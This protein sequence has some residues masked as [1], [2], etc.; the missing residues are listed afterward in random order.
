MP[1]INLSDVTLKDVPVQDLLLRL[2]IG[3]KAATLAGLGVCAGYLA[4]I[5]KRLQSEAPLSAEEFDE[6]FA[7]G[8]QDVSDAYNRIRTVD[9]IE[10]PSENGKADSQE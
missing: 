4:A 1:K 3:D 8:Q 6:A 2:S 9:S 10:Y 5:L 7:A